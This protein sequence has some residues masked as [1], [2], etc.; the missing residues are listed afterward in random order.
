M[1]DFSGKRYEEKTFCLINSPAE[2]INISVNINYSQKSAIKVL[3]LYINLCYI[4][5]L[6]LEFS[7]SR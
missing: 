1:Q 3:T 5:C 4:K 2:V 7:K 6:V